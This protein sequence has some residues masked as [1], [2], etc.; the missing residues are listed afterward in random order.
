L[1]LGVYV[2]GRRSVE[3]V[4]LSTHDCHHERFSLR[5]R[6]LALLPPSAARAFAAS[7]IR[8]FL[9]SVFCCFRRPHKGLGYASRRV[10]RSECYERDDRQRTGVK[11]FIERYEIHLLETRQHNKNPT[12]RPEISEFMK[13]REELGKQ[14]VDA[15]MS[16]LMA[17]TF[18]GNGWGVRARAMLADAYVREPKPSDVTEV[19]EHSDCLPLAA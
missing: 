14:F 17:M 15:L 2:W 8:V 3:S 13:R 16:G 1:C 7:R 11:T 5:L 12:K 9:K 19:F 4:F 6:H 10:E 18:L